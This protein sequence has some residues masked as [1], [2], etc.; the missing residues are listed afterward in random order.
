M[1]F[2][3]PV[4]PAAA[5]EWGRTLENNPDN[6]AEAQ[7]AGRISPIDVGRKIFSSVLSIPI[8][9]L[10]R[11]VAPVAN[12]L[13]Q[14]YVQNKQPENVQWLIDEGVTFNEL[15]DQLTYM[16]SENQDLDTL[17]LL[18]QNGAPAKALME[19]Y[20]QERPEVLRKIVADYDIRLNY[21]HKKL[22]NMAASKGDTETLR[23]LLDHEGPISEGAPMFEKEFWLQWAEQRPSEAFFPSHYDAILDGS[24]DIYDNTC[25]TVYRAVRG[26]HLDSLKLLVERGASV[27]GGGAF[28][29]IYM[30]RAAFKADKNQEKIVE[31]LLDNHLLSD[32]MLSD[33]TERE[34]I[35]KDRM[36]TFKDAVEANCSD[37]VLCLMLREYGDR[38]LDN[39]DVFTGEKCK[40]LYKKGLDLGIF[41]APE[42]F[43]VPKDGE[44]SEDFKE[45]LQGVVFRAHNKLEEARLYKRL[46][47]EAKLSV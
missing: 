32:H 14:R 43:E 25:G 10:A 20:M 18:L 42:D 19:S 29:N 46:E 22:V 23:V 5:P 35:K 27:D 34:E 26:G 47:V 15:P 6:A 24:W 33:C 21:C 38:G 7:S 44:D 36:V 9:L 41:E 12:F 31:F 13:V 8:S 2:G 16:A 45:I 37:H 3:M 39:P 11:N 1:S 30:L 17:K 40:S 4:T 28:Y